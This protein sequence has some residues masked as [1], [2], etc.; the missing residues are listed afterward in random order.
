MGEIKLG[1]VKGDDGKSVY[2][3]YNSVPSDTGAEDN[4]D[5]GK[6]KYIGVI[7]SA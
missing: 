5:V 1:R 4:W 6:H 7:T 2:I 3:K